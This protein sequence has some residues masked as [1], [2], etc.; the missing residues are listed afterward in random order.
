MSGTSKVPN[1]TGDTEQNILL[2]PW[3]KTVHFDVTAALLKGP[4]L[5]GHG[6]WLRI[7]LKSPL[8]CSNSCSRFCSQTRSSSLMLHHTTSA[9]KEFLSLRD[10][11]TFLSS[12]TNMAWNT[13]GKLFFKMEVSLRK[14]YLLKLQEINFSWA[15]THI[16]CSKTYFGEFFDTWTT[17]AS[18]EDVRVSFWTAASGGDT[19]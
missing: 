8:P 6:Q 18:R 7:V 11:S 12:Q 9:T 16:F 3:N 2:L 19:G 13:Q 17:A 10:L 5:K 4:R 1:P 14:M 15:E